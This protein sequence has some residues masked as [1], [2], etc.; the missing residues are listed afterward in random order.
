MRKFQWR[1]DRVLDVRHQQ[2]QRVKFELIDLAGQLV[3]ARADLLAQRE[4]LEQTARRV[5]GLSGTGRVHQQRLFLESS[6]Q[7]D[8]AIA[9]LKSRIQELKEQQKHK[10]DEYRQ[11]HSSCQAMEK[12]REKAKEQWLQEQNAAE[13]KQLDEAVTT[14]FARKVLGRAEDR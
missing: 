7:T 10:R 2:K 9:Q 13:Q 11:L 14:A 3:R 8:S 6:G 1:L 4:I 5:G 12:L